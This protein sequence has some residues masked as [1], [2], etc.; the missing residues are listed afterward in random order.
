MKETFSSVFSLVLATGIF[1]LL[2][3]PPVLPA[4]TPCDPPIAQMVSVQ[5][6]V[7]VRRAGQTQ[8]QPAR[9]NETY[10]PGDR[11]Q[12]GDKSRADIALVNQPVLRLDQN[13]LITLAGVK[14][15]R[16]SV[17]DL[18]RGA[19]HF[20]SRLPRNLEVN[21][22]FVNAGVEGTEGLVQVEG[23]RTLITI[24]EGRVLA[25]N[26]AG[27][28]PIASGQSAVAVQGQAPV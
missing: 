10:C 27:S 17:I 20:F 5:G 12:V 25:A 19:L 14:D 28:L 11:I 21:T 1:E 22:A 2:L 16:A 4:A 15:E 24:F 8:S 26:A 18:A 7:V 23:D 3:Q 13:T 6:N 9:L